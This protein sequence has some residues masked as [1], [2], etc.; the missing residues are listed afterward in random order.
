MAIYEFQCQTCGYIFEEVNVDLKSAKT[1][2]CPKCK[3]ISKKIL[4]S[5]SFIINGFNSN[6]GY[7]GHMR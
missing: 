7:S 2:E 1:K 6:N 3:N 4:S 5:G